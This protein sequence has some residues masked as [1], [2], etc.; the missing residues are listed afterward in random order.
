MEKKL[1]KHIFYILQITDS[2]RF[3]ASSLSNLVSNLSEKIHRIKYKFGYNDK[4]S[5]TSGIKYRYC[6]CFLEYKK[7]KDELIECKCLCCNKNYQ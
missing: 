1:Q 6:N 2:A 7:F 5:E 3:M 4:K